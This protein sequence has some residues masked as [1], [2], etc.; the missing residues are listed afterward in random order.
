M[1]PP[2]P[3]FHT[4]EQRTFLKTF[5][6]FFYFLFFFLHLEFTQASPPCALDNRFYKITFEGCFASMGKTHVLHLVHM[7]NGSGFGCYSAYT[8]AVDFSSRLKGEPQQDLLVYYFSTS[9]ERYHCNELAVTTVA[10]S[11]A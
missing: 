2:H 11:I 7:D 9:P 1:P 4:T 6:F 8:M 3:P 5:F 10:S